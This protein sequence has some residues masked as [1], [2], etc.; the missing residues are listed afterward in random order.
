MPPTQQFEMVWIKRLAAMGGQLIDL[1]SK[2]L[3]VSTAVNASRDPQRCCV[4]DFVHSRGGR[5]P[6]CLATVC[7]T[8]ARQKA[9]E[10]GVRKVGTNSRPR[11]AHAR[12]TGAGAPRR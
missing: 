12:P 6:V 5:K 8:T 1:G 3:H 10:T 4:C 7:Q 2:G 11:G 9:Y